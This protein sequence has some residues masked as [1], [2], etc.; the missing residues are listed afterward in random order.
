M[1]SNQITFIKL[2]YEVV[3]ESLFGKMERSLQGL[4]GIFPLY[5]YIT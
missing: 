2:L 1:I 4:R 3:T 5:L